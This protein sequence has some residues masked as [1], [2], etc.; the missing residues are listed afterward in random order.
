VLENPNRRRG[1]T[2]DPRPLRYTG[3]AE[4][5]LVNEL[6]L[7]LMF[8]TAPQLAARG[9]SASLH[10]LHLDNGRVE[11]HSALARIVKGKEPHLQRQPSLEDLGCDH[12]APD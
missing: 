4:S 2:K 7:V 10:E 6:I 3:N 1:T 5:D 8:R 12:A 11:P 9:K